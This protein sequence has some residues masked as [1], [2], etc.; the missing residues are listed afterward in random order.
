MTQSQRSLI[1]AR[2]YPVLSLFDEVNRLFDDALPHAGA[3]A[4]SRFAPVLDVTESDKDYLIQGDFPG[5]EGQDVQIEVKDNSIT[6]SGERRQERERKE[7]ERTYVERSF[8]SFS[9]TIP[10]SVEIDEDRATAEMK[11]GVLTIQVPKSEKVV[12]GVKKITVKSS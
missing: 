4:S 2:Q 8:G 6:L 1:R 10:F 12:R 3:S 11:N 7:G 9:R 5:F